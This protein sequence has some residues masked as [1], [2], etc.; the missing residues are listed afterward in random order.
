MNGG[1]ATIHSFN[2]SDS[3]EAEPQMGI[4]VD[5]RLRALDTM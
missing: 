3:D 5:D 1:T 2:E 4:S